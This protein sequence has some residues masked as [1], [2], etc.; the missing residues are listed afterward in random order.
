MERHKIRREVHHYASHGMETGEVREGYFTKKYSYKP[1]WGFI[2][3]S[4]DRLKPFET[5]IYNLY[6]H[7]LLPY[8]EA[9]SNRLVKLE[10][11]AKPLTT[12]DIEEILT[13]KRGARWR[14]LDEAKRLGI[15]RY[16]K[17]DKAFYVNPDIVIIGKEVSEEVFNLFKVEE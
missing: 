1:K 9:E 16:V 13:I 5:R 11:Y 3:M 12:S 4:I 17:D 14:F 2:K 15:I 6:F 10:R 7:E 8:L